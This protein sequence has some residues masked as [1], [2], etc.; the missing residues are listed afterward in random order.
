MKIEKD[1]SGSQPCGQEE[2]RGEISASREQIENMFSK[3]E[4][5]GVGKETVSGSETP[6]DADVYPEEC[7][8]ATEIS[9]EDYERWKEGS[10]KG[11][12]RTFIENR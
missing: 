10:E 9:D 1:M 8:D 12:W 11:F 6:G 7:C 5:S 3:A 2:Q 4:A